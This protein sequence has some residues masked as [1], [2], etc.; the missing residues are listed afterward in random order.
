MKHGLVVDSPSR[1]VGE[2]VHRS[3]RFWC[4]A[5]LEAAAARVHGRHRVAAGM[6]SGAAG[7]ARPAWTEASAPPGSPWQGGGGRV[8]A[9]PASAAGE[10]R[11][12]EGDGAGGQP[13]GAR[14]SASRGR[15]A[16]GGGKERG[17]LK[18]YDM[19]AS[20]TTAGCRLM[21]SEGRRPTPRRIRVIGRALNRLSCTRRGRGPWFGAR[22]GDSSTARP[23]LGPADGAG[24]V[25]HLAPLAAALLHVKPAPERALEVGAGTGEGSLLMSREFPQASVRGIDLSEEM[26]R[27]ASHEG[28]AG[29]GG[30]DR[31]SGGGRGRPPLRGRVV[32]P[33]RPPQHAAVRRRG[34]A[35]PAARRPGDRRLELGQATPFYTPRAVLDWGFAKRGIEPDAAGESCRH[36]LGRART[37]DGSAVERVPGHPARDG[38]HPGGVSESS[39]TR[40]P[41]MAG[42]RSHLMI[43]NPSAGGGRA[44]KRAARAG[45]ALRARGLALQARAHHG[46]R[47]RPRRGR[48][49]AAAGEIPVVVSGDGL[50]GQVGGEL[51]GR[52][53]RWG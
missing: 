52:R 3:R 49:A 53:R 44:R 5:R 18:M 24:S 19:N 47:A 29:S 8:V 39:A 27:T 43:V 16:S 15:L 50:I 2:R 38:G 1:E 21:A 14:S 10:R 30:P 40:L 34:G 33:R 17:A 37:R 11:C 36:V 46:R 48:D 51:A 7:E 23:R 6:V 45:G 26:I 25:N 32:R 41:P 9:I 12:G 4:R 31:V 28:R 42:D 13:C 35:R 20:T 22:C